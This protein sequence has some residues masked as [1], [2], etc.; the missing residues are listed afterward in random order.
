[1][2]LAD[3][4]HVNAAK[5]GDRVAV[6]CGVERVTYA[7]LLARVK[8]A[9]DNLRDAG[10]GPGDLIEV[11]LPDSPNHVVVLYALARLGAVSM[12]VAQGRPHHETATQYRDL[13]VRLTITKSGRAP[14]PG[15]RGLAVSAVCAPG[16]VSDATAP[17]HNAPFDENLALMLTQSSGTTGQP[18]RLFATHAQIMARGLRQI[19]IMSLTSADRFL[20]EPNLSF[21]SG[22]RRCFAMLHVGGTVVILHKNLN[23]STEYL[24]YFKERNIT[25]FFASPVRLEGLLRAARKIGAGRD[26][27]LYPDLK[28][29]VSSGPSRSGHRRLAREKLTPNLLESYGTNELG[30]LT[31]AR[32]ADHARYPESV[33]RLIDGIQAQVVDDTDRPLAP[34]QVGLVGFR[35][36]DLP[37]AYIG[38][39]DATVKGFRGGWFYPGDLAALNEEG[40]V[41][42]KGRADDVINYNGEKFYPIEIEN[43]LLSHP[44]VAEAAVVGRHY[45]ELQV[46]VAFIVLTAKLSITELEDHCK[47]MIA[48]HKAPFHFETVA[49][50][51]R[52]QNGKVLKRD[53]KR[54]FERKYNLSQ[55]EADWAGD[56]RP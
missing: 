50:L 54:D 28:L 32:P 8:M 29:V 26:G 51:P 34:G 4:L 5:Q 19:K 24:A 38:D 48:D 36:P 43:V 22:S 40:Y 31:V 16:A 17:A 27:P 42:L 10:V 2:N 13:D 30:D 41:F 45:K 3:S 11:M 49:R 9:L 56:A 12:S 55:A 47:S 7:E 1:V 44:A 14:L 21:M 25:Y 23:R 39:A 52:T 46:G 20:Q 15:D 6:E 37:P 33:G 35:A 18:K 53:L